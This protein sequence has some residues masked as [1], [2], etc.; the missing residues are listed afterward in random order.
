MDFDPSENQA[1][2]AFYNWDENINNW[3]GDSKVEKSFNEY[4]D[5]TYEAYFNWDSLTSGF[6][7]PHPASGQ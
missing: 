7:H 2:L 4:G 5:L 6:I 3:I 1:L